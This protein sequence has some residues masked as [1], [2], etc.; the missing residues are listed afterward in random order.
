MGKILKTFKK[1]DV[2][3][4]DEYQKI[5]EHMK[6]TPSGLLIPDKPICGFCGR[7]LFKHQLK[8]SYYGEEFHAQCALNMREGYEND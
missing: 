5:I 3:N 8:Q 6:Q 4:P 2:R 7:E 1:D